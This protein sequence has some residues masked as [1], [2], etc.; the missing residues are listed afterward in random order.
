MHAAALSV[1]IL[2]GVVAVAHAA[3]ETIPLKNAAQPGQ[4][5]PAIGLGT[6]G[7][8]ANKVPYGNYPECWMVRRFAVPI[9]VLFFLDALFPC[10]S[11]RA[12]ETTRSRL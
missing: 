11:L 3:G 7:Y 8:G 5:M 10:R 12:V 6:G 9:R 1:A 4:T 2:S